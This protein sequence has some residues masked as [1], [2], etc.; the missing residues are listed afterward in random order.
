MKEYQIDDNE[1][2]IVL[3]PERI[4]LYAPMMEKGA[5]L[6]VGGIPENVQFATALVYLIKTDADFRAWV[7]EK[8]YGL[9]DKFM[10]EQHVKE[11]K[12][13]V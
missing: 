8:W 11:V 2:V 4:E 9:V 13:E 5:E 6:P 12:D 10:A 1:A 7:T 3:G